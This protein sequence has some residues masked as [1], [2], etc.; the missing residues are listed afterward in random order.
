MGETIA[1]IKVMGLTPNGTT[2][3]EVVVDTGATYTALPKR[4]LLPLGIKP[5]REITIELA[6]GQTLRRALGYAIVE[7]EGRRSPNVVILGEEG[8][9][10]VVGL[11]TLESCGLMVDPLNR[12]LIPAPKIHHY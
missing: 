11:V 5:E 6:N 4:T 1:K 9:A 10:A 12:R 2:E 3:V 7:V 8:D